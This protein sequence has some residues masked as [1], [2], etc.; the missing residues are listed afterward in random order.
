MHVA[1]VAGRA[2]TVHALACVAA[3]HTAGASCSGTCTGL[4]RQHGVYLPGVFPCALGLPKRHLTEKPVELVRQI[5]RLAPANGVV[6][7]L[8][9]GS[10][11]FLVAAKEAGLAWIGCETNAR[12][13]DVASRRLLAVECADSVATDS[14]GQAGGL[15]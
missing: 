1:Y 5:V 3:A 14:S 11:T 6:C 15:G 7:D 13:Y 4:L 2:S 10:G 12:Y 8:F 9:A